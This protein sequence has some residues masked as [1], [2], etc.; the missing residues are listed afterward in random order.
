MKQKLEFRES[1]R[2]YC[3]IKYNVRS[4]LQI[5]SRLYEADHV[6]NTTEAN[7]AY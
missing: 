2:A 4:L 5:V 3:Y 1:L 7:S 6:T